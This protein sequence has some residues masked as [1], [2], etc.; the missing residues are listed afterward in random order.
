MRDGIRAA[1][2]PADGSHRPVLLAERSDREK[3]VDDAGLEPRQR[4]RE[5]DMHDVE[6]EVGAR[7][8]EGAEQGPGE[9]PD[10]W[11][12]RSPAVNRRR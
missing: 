3:H 10:P 5:P 4:V 7:V 1:T 8:V 6:I 2:A 12:M 11:S 9:L